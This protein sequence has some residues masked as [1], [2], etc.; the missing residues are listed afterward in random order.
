MY[1]LSYY[2]NANRI[3]LYEYPTMD[4]AMNW[5]G[6]LV[7]AGFSDGYKLNNQLCA[8]MVESFSAILY[9]YSFH[10]SHRLFPKSCNLFYRL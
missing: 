4:N 2:M 9:T 10:M 3:L 1:N 7:Q 6:C 8:T 5:V